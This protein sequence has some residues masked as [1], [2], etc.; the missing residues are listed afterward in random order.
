MPVEALVFSGYDAARLRYGTGVGEAST[1]AWLDPKLGIPT[2]APGNIVR[3]PVSSRP[4]LIDREGYRRPIP[5]NTTFDCLT[6]QGAQVVDA[7]ASAIQLMAARTVSALCDKRINVLVA[8]TGDGSKPASGTRIRNDAEV[9]E[10][11]VPRLYEVVPLEHAAEA[12]RSMP[13]SIV[14]AS[15]LLLE[16]APERLARPAAFAFEL[17]LH[18]DDEAPPLAGRE[19]SANR[20]MPAGL[21]AQ[22]REM[23]D[24]PALERAVREHDRPVGGPFGRMRRRQRHVIRLPE[25]GSR[26][27]TTK[28]SANSV[29]SSPTRPRPGGGCGSRR[30]SAPPYSRRRSAP[31]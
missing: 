19:S 10:R 22:L 15:A 6:T 11:A 4:W 27:L 16:L 25:A 5:D 7:A 29:A 17:R 9:R 8:G 14:C 24:R 31:V 26:L 28:M 12:P 2:V 13:Y 20:A 18:P 23:D 30:R 3:D 1:A 21:V